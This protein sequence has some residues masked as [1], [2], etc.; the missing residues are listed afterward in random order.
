MTNA[1]TTSDQYGSGRP[2]TAARSTSGWA[3]STRS[4]SCDD[5]FMPPDLIMSLR[6]SWK[7]RLPS[8]STRTM[9][10][11][12]SQPAPKTACGALGLVVVA[13]H[14]RRRA[15]DSARRAR[16]RR[17][18]RRRR[19]SRGASP[20]C[21]STTGRP[22]GCRRAWRTSRPCPAATAPTAPSRC[23]TARP[24]AAAAHASIAAGDT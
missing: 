13:E 3:C 20:A 10:P 12:R 17:R 11:V 14:H 24:G 23:P 5:T 6:R 4:T 8:A 18:P 15:A 2:T 1:V 22:P 16:R 21:R 19:A 9:S 7:N